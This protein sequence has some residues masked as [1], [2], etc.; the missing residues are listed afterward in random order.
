MKKLRTPLLAII[1]L[2]INAIAFAD[3]TPTEE[4]KKTLETLN[5]Q[6]E[7]LSESPQD[8]RN[9]F[10]QFKT[11]RDKF[12]EDEKLNYLLSEI[13]SATYKTFSKQ[14]QEEKAKARENKQKIVHQHLSNIND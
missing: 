8:L 1:I 14:K 5:Q 13:T 12:T 3:Y 2:G 6:I 11:L 9:F 10:Y 7:K 4:D